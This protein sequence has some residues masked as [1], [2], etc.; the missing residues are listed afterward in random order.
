MKD[1]I[2]GSWDF[3]IFVKDFRSDVELFEEPQGELGERSLQKTA[4]RSD[5]LERILVRIFISDSLE[6]KIFN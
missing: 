3:P 1:T 2:D 4:N 5:E 6:D